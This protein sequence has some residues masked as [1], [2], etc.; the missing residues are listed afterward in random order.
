MIAQV[1]KRPSSC[2]VDV[3]RVDEPPP[4]LRFAT[5]AEADEAGRAAAALRPGS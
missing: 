4:E 5:Y 1:T 3:D 2:V